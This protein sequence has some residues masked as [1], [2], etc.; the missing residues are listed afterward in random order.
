MSENEANTN[1]V[2]HIVDGI[3]NTFTKSKLVDTKQL[4][5]QFRKQVKNQ[6]IWITVGFIGAIILFLYIFKIFELATAIVIILCGVGLR[7][8]LS[9]K[10]PDPHK[11]RLEIEKYEDENK[12]EAFKIN[13]DDAH[14]DKL[15]KINMDD[16]IE[17][18]SLSQFYLSQS[19]NAYL[20][21]GAIGFIFLFTSIILGN[22]DKSKELVYLSAFIGILLELAFCYFLYKHQNNL[23][24]LTSIDKSIE[25]VQNKLLLLK[26]IE[27]V[28]DPKDRLSLIQ[29]LIDKIHD[30]QNSE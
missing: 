2:N 25:K 13:L 22:N 5:E 9:V 24:Q 17:N 7:L 18:V 14:F 16:L 12:S 28:E 3:K 11:L 15:I 21:I 26:L 6:K 19:F 27:K 30:T 8:I 1:K 10:I 23:K 20:T 4:A 29:N